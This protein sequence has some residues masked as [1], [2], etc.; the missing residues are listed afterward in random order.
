MVYHAALHGIQIYELEAEVSGDLDLQGFM[1]LSHEVRK[2][3]S[4][5]KV[6]FRVKSDIGD[7]ERLKALAEYSPVYDVLCNGTNVEIEVAKM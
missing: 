1:G 5:I 7:T 3:L 2:G 4:D 6:N